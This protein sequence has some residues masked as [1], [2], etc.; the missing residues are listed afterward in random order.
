M[1]NHV[2]TITVLG[3]AAAA[4]G[5][6]YAAVLAL[7]ARRRAYLENYNWPPGLMDRLANH[8]PD[9]SAGERERV[10][11]GLK[12]FFSAYLESGRKYVAMPSEVVDQL[13]HEFILYTR[14]YEE[15]CNEA[16]G[17]FLHHTPAVV[18]SKKRRN[19]NE[20]LRRVWAHSCRAEGIDPLKAT[21]LPL[22]FALDRDLKIPGGYVYQP[23]CNALREKQK[24]KGAS[25]DSG[26]GSPHCGTDFASTSFDGGTEGM[27]DGGIFSGDGD[28]GGCGG[29]CG[30]D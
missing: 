8:Y 20:G 29:G 1:I 18:L 2:L 21:T 12:Q 26:G 5:T 9:L 28:G 23:D 17:R 19:N 27:D 30:G 25:G 15:F 13:W 10:G 14:H 11:R 3:A 7:K 24:G 22:L 6:A 16:F 4:A